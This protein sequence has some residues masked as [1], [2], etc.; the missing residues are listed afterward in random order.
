MNETNDPNLFNDN[1][2]GSYVYIDTPNGKTAYGQLTLVDNPE[3]DAKAQV[4]AGGKDRRMENDFWGKDDGG[5]LIGARFGGAPGAENLTPQNRNL[6]RSAYKSMEDTWAEAL[7]NG[8]KV[9]VCVS[10]HNS[11]DVQ[12][13]TAYSGYYIIEHTDENGKTTRDAEYFS[14]NNESNAT[15]DALDEEF[16]EFMSEHPEIDEEAMA[17]N[18]TM[19]YIWDEDKQEAVKNPYYISD[20]PSTEQQKSSEYA[21]VVGENTEVNEAVATSSYGTTPGKEGETTSTQKGTDYSPPATKASIDNDVVNI[22]DY[23]PVTPAATTEVY[24]EANADYT[25]NTAA[26]TENST[27][28]YAPASSIQGQSTQDSSAEQGSDVGADNSTGS[29]NDSGQDLD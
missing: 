15:M 9:Y 22:S 11:T 23:A 2:P 14:M 12:R 29:D 20:E 16:N 24:S 28:D 21:P 26:E 17:E 3:R 19:E 8:D 7:R 1:P 13:P 4:E 27:S 5:H 10:S 18:T 6:N 25:P